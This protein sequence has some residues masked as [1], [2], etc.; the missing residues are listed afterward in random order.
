MT[1]QRHA[2]LLGVTKTPDSW[3]FLTERQ[4]ELSIIAFQGPLPGVQP[5]GH[6]GLWLSP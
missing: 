2:L 1:Q 6:Q 4:G 3:A 5:C